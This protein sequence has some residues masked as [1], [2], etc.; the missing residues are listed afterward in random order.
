MISR[1]AGYHIHTSWFGS[2]QIVNRPAEFPDLNIDPLVFSLTEE[3]RL[4]GSCGSTNPNSVYMRD[5]KCA[6]NYPKPSLLET[7]FD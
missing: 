5:G 3:F 7:L 2:L 4:H 1:S 6:K